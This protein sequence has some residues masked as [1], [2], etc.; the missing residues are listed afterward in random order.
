MDVLQAE[1][2]ACQTVLLQREADLV[3]QEAEHNSKVRAPAVLMLCASC[4]AAAM[5]QPCFW[6]IIAASMQIYALNQIIQAYV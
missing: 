3:K 1:F 2:A 4:C 6:D 5:Q